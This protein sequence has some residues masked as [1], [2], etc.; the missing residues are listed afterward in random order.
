MANRQ[1]NI[2]DIPQEFIKQMH[3]EV[4][5]D[6]RVRQMRIKQNMAQRSGNFMQALNIGKA[7]EKL[8]SLAL[9]AWMEDAEKAYSVIDLKVS[10][11]PEDDRDVLAEIVLT[12]FLAA[13]IIDTATRD[14]NDIIHKTDKDIDLSQFEDIQGLSN[15]AKAKLSY[16]SKHSDYLKDVDWG[17]KSDDMYEMLRHK[18][19]KLMRNHE[20]TEK[21]EGIRNA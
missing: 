12:L 13:D 10:D 11:L 6:P 2:K 14:F 9:Q 3:D 18:A 15:A 21:N 19:R 20:K 8:H 5:A 1:I 4:E 17:E 16:L 7:I